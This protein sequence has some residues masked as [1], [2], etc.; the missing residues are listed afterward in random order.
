MFHALVTSISTVLRPCV[1]SYL[2]WLQASDVGVV[3]NGIKAGENVTVDYTAYVVA[4]PERWDV[5][6]FEPTFFTNQIWLMRVVA[7]PGESVSFDSD[8]ITVDGRSLVPPPHLTNVA[9][10]G[11]GHPALKDAGSVIASPYLVPSDSY[12]VLGDNSTNSND[13]RMWGGV[14]HTNIFGKVRGK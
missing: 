5:V 2:A 3:F 10:V 14:F 1:R 13:S 11:L 12:F 6:A 9:L 8:G 7:L 4:S